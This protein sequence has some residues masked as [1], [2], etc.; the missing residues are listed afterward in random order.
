[1]TKHRLTRRDFMER[2][3]GAAAA[4]IASVPTLLNAP[5][6]PA[7]EAP[8]GGDDS[9]APQGLAECPSTRRQ[10]AGKDYQP[11]HQG[12]R[13][14]LI[15]GSYRGIDEFA[16]DELQRMTQQYV[17]YVLE[18]RPA[19]EPVDSDAHL[20]LLGTTASNPLLAELEKKGSLMVPGKPEGYAC[21]CMQSPWN[22]QRKCVVIAGADS[23]GTLYGVMQ[24][25]QKL[26]ALTPDD[27]REMRQTLD[28]LAE[29]NTREWPAI[30]NRGVWS[31]GYVIYDYR[32]FIDNLARLR[33]N[34]LLFWNDIPPLNCHSIIDYAHA[35]GVRVV[36]GFPWG[37]GMGDLD[38]NSR[39][40]RQL[41]KDDVICRI[42]QF[43][44]HLGMDAI[45]FQT[46]TETTK[47]EIGGNLLAVLARDWVND[48]AGAVLARYPNLRIEWGL[49]ATSI[50]ENYPYLE[51]LDPRI[52]IV[53]E[54]AGVIPY[55]YDPITQSRKGSFPALLD[56][57]AATV[58]YSKKLATFRANREFAMV[59]KGWTNLRWETEFE[60][61]GPFILG[62]R[63]P[64]FIR[65]RLHERQPRW[66][67]VNRLWLEN[68][69]EALRFF[70]EILATSPSRMTVLGLIED[71]IFEEK[72]Q[73]SAALFAEMIWNPRRSAKEILE[74]ALN[75][76][77]ARVA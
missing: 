12:P 31:W 34:R 77:Y 52:A 50:L 74:S 16:L 6:L 38:P 28:N 1:M 11:R 71:G 60:H 13:W 49:H 41:I 53:W 54:D 14:Q 9:I 36:L 48:I 5:S 64:D 47:K 33:M 2:S 68:Y 24:F 17:P 18:V 19:V 70:E 45:Y 42:D 4:S 15:Y 21:A 43:Y 29:F 75:P 59:A 61:H 72:I 10:K 67:Y 26:A 20:I 37:W 55:A 23:S 62:E 57:P 46:F 30:D 8:A 66:D 40:D 32:R 27:P 39:E 25:N 58:E 44:A 56:T 65:N 3:A 76:Y 51:S 22:P 63:A 69:P 73:V 7:R 35:R